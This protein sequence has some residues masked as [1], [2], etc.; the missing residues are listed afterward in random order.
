M[1]SREKQTK[2]PVRRRFKEP[3]GAV[4]HER[5]KERPDESND[6]DEIDRVLDKISETGLESLTADE[7]RLLD[8]ASRR[9]RKH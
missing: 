7:R 4:H 3:V 6:Y 8:E 5:S 1:A 9:L 2:S